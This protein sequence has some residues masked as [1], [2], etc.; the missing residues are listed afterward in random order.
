MSTAIDYTFTPE[1]VKG[2]R[3]RLGMT[4]QDFADKLG[5]HSNTVNLWEKGVTHPTRGPQLKALLDADAEV[6]GG[7]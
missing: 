5:V 6:N 1:R 3:I 7:R 4:Q 2:I